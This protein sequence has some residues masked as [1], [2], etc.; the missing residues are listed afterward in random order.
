[1]NAK[2]LLSAALLLVSCVFG[3]PEEVAQEK[4]ANGCGRCPR[5]E[6]SSSSSSHI[7]ECGLDHIKIVPDGGFYPF[8]FQVPY[9]PIQQDFY[10]KSDKLTILTVVD[11][12]CQG[13]AFQFY[14]NGSL[15]GITDSQCPPFDPVTYP[16]PPPDTPPTCN[17]YGPVKST[18]YECYESVLYCKG[19][20]FLLPGFHNISLQTILSPMSGGTAFLRV[21]TACQTANN[22]LVPCC[23]L[24]GGQMY[25]GLAAGFAM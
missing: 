6:S 8:S 3:A 24:P 19:G 22:E 2:S 23:M 15:I 20:A 25:T 5:K 13:D 14:D 7:S 18:P 21:D 17:P 9:E 12:F 10:F 16:P 11:C 4:A 1:M